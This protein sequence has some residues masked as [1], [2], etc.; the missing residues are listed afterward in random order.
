MD[1]MR[2]AMQ[3]ADYPSTRGK[4]TYG[5]NHFPV[6]NFYLREVVADADGMWTVKTVE[7]VFENHQDRY[8]GECA[9]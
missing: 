6:Q 2:A 9:M 3:K 5:K 4:Y 8:V 1:G 7:T